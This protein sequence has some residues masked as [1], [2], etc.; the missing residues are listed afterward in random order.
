[1]VALTRALADALK[2]LRLMSGSELIAALPKEMTTGL[3]TKEFG[4]IIAR[5]RDALYPETV[6]IDLPAAQRVAQT[7]VVGGLI[8]DQQYLRPARHHDCGELVRVRDLTISYG[9]EP[10]LEG[11]SIEVG[12]GRV[13]E[14]RRAV[15]LGQVEP[16]AR[17]DRIAAAARRHG[18]CRLQAYP[19]SAC[20]SRT[21]RCC[22]GRP[23][24]TMSRSDLTFAGMDRK[25]ALHAGR[26]LARQARTRG[27]RP[28][29]S[30]ASLRRTAQARRHR[31]GAGDAAQASA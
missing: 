25:L 27:I 19:R 1:M 3:D 14:P 22:P 9:D 11:A 4:D 29:L 31:A 13:R 15:R 10:V 16:A 30:A 24:A 26:L 21:T 20:C 12:V 5:H 28:P 18:R 7:L 17:R 23:R 8:K 2:A 6:S